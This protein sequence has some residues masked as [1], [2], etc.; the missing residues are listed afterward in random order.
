MPAEIL[1]ARVCNVCGVEKPVEDLVPSKRNRGGFMPCCKPC[2]NEYF[3]RKRASSAEVRE[4]ESLR[5]RRS[6]LLSD[7]GMRDADYERMVAEQG[8]MCKL[9][10][11]PETGRSE[12]FRYWNI[13][14]DHKTGRVR[15]LLCHICNITVGKFEALSDRI[16]QARILD[17]IKRE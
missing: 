11:A 16:G 9:C 3:R 2:R 14:H 12:R 7:Y 4:R 13:D 8:G 5:V 1:D 6:R 15:G 17:Y 10:G